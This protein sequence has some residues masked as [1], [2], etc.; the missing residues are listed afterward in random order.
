MKMTTSIKNFN[1]C[2]RLR[3]F[4]VI[5]FV[6][7]CFARLPQAQAACQQGCLTNANTA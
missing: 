2:A 5:P 1:N 4:L 6:L 3:L 7:A